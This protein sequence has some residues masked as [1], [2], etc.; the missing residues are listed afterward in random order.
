MVVGGR[1]LVG[2]WWW[3]WVRRSLVVGCWLMVGCWFLVVGCWLLRA[4]RRNS[5]R[6]RQCARAIV[7]LVGGVGRI[8]VAVARFVGRWRGSASAPSA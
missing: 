2:G 8:Y 3:S 1:W 6:L 5:R 7:G 4:G